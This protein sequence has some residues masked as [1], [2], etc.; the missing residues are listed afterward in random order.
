[1]GRVGRYS[2][3]AKAA[4]R[5][6]YKACGEAGGTKRVASAE[7]AA[8]RRKVDPEAHRGI[9]RRRDQKLREQTWAAYGGACLGCGET[10]GCCLTIDHIFDDGAAERRKGGR[11]GRAGVGFYRY[12]RDT[13]F[14]QDRYQLLCFNC[15]YR[16]RKHGPDIASW[17]KPYAG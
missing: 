14:P 8:A 6:A 4:G 17:P 5:A 15:Q 9:L 16:K 1:M 10:E 7:S 13:G 2:A 11:E 3:A 12:L